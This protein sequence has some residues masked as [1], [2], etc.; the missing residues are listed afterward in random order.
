VKIFKRN[1][2]GHSNQKKTIDSLESSGKYEKKNKEHVIG[3][4]C[5]NILNL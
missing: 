3:S 2:S 5:G 1:T 4:K